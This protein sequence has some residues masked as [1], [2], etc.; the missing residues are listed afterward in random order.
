MTGCTI[1]NGMI[2]LQGKPAQQVHGNG[3]FNDP[4]I[5]IVASGTIGPQYILVHVGMTGFTFTLY[6]LKFQCFVAT[7]AINNLMLTSEFKMGRIMI[8]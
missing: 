6:F 2:S 3:V 8:E 7:A 1:Q 5:G 4:G